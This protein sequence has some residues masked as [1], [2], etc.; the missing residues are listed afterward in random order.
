M[1]E[2]SFSALIFLPGVHGGTGERLCMSV[3]RRSVHLAPVAPP[4]LQARHPAAHCSAHPYSRFNKAMKMRWTM[5]VTTARVRGW[6]KGQEELA[7]DSPSFIS[8]YFSQFLFFVLS[9]FAHWRASCPLDKWWK[10]GH[11][12]VWV[13]R[14]AGEVYTACPCF[15]QTISAVKRGHTKTKKKLV[16]KVRERVAAC[17][18]GMWLRLLCDW[19]HRR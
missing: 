19:Q 10:A 7:D 16:G 9:L 12:G 3:L 18:C 4:Q 13:W 1:T 17:K 14:L 8:F 5:D 11:G 2:V 15:K 6:K